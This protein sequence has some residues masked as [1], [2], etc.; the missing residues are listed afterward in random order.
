MPNQA[1]SQLN[2]ASTLTGAEIVPIVQSG[3]TVRTTVTSINNAVFAY[4]SFF[5]SASQTLAAGENAIS[6][7][8]AQTFNSGITLN[9]DRL[10]FTIISGGFYT[11]TANINVTG[12]GA[13]NTLNIYPK[14]G[15]ATSSFSSISFLSSGSNSNPT[16]FDVNFLLSCSAG[17]TVGLFVTGST[18]TLLFSTPSTGTTPGIPSISTY[19][20]RVG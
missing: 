6:H 18:S 15:G 12:S 3:T 2:A 10:G 7:S 19:I 1:I 9:S 20:H 17:T 4:G 14:V 13:N 8:S 16:S 11:L 5:N